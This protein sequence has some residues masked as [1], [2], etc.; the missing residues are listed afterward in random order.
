MRASQIGIALAPDFADV[1][2]PMHLATI[3]A[4]FKP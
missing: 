2:S 3:E 4:E 1:H